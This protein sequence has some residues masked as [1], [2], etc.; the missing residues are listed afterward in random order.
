M[1]KVSY[2]FAIFSVFS[3]FGYAQDSPLSLNLNDGMTINEG[4]VFV[5]GEVNAHH[6]FSYLNVGKPNF[7][8]KKGGIY[9]PKSLTGVEVVVAAIQ[10]SP[11]GHK[12]TLKRRDANR[13]LGA[14]KLIYVKDIENALAKGELLVKEPS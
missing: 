14:H 1:K 5:I 7:T 12:I 11:K 2:L 8:I 13:F 6:A 9:N 4:D 10:S 3:F